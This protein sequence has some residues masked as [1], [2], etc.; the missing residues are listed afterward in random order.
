MAG[1]GAQHV[2]LNK[3]K[4]NIFFFFFLNAGTAHCADSLTRNFIGKFL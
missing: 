3:I 2:L 1:G 4:D